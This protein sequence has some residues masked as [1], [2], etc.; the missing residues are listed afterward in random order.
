MSCN[1]TLYDSSY[2]KHNFSIQGFIFRNSISCQGCDFKQ[3]TILTALQKRVLLVAPL[4]DLGVD[5]GV[6]D[7]KI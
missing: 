7:P 5:F 2:W 4:F 6:F 3:V 1:V